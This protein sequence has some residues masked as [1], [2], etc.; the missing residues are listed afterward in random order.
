[1][2]PTL[3][4]F[5]QP[6]VR[7]LRRC[8]V[9]DR[10]ADRTEFVRKTADWIAHHG[11]DAE[12]VFCAN[13][14]V[15]ER[16]EA[17]TEFFMPVHDVYRMKI[18]T[19]QRHE[20]TE[21]EVLLGFLQPGGTLFDVGANAGV[22]S[23]R[24]ARRG[25]RVM[26]FEPVAANYLVLEKNIAR[27]RLADRITPLRVALG[28]V[29]R[30]VRMPSGFSTGSHVVAGSEVVGSGAFEMVSMRT[31]DAF[32]AESGLRPSV[33]KIDA[34]GYELRVL[35]GARECLRADR[36][37]LLLEIAEE[38]TTRFGYRPAEIVRFLREH[39][40]VCSALLFGGVVHERPEGLPDDRLTGNVVFVP[41]DAIAP[42]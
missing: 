36:P 17:G 26:A 10:W 30:T 35:E 27:N 8:V 24:V 21:T 25:F 38:W 42:R 6:L 39:N 29:E 31:I 15:Y 3:P 7:R 19:G 14:D 9:E 28:E 32:R 2:T 22:H 11:L 13:G 18:G 4:R 12:L 1:M 37:P 20:S 5:V 33:I 16:D 41:C 40:Y 34:E 23:V